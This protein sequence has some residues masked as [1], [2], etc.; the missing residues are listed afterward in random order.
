MCTAVSFCAA[1]R[2]F[3]RNLDLECF[4]DEAVTLLPRRAEVQ[5]LS[6]GRLARHAAVLGTA[7]VVQGRALY[8]D[9]MNEHGLAMAALHFPGCAHY[10]PATGSG[11][12]VASFELTE[13]LLCR[14]ASLSEARRA[15]QGLR[16]TDAAFSPDFPP[17]PL[18]WM[19]SDGHR[20]LVIEPTQQ[21]VQVHENP[22]GVLTNAPEFDWH[23]K[24]W[25]RFSLL[26]PE[27]RAF[28]LPGDHSSAA[29]FV[30]AHYVLQHSACAPEQE[31]SQLLGILGAVQV[32]RGSVRTPAGEAF[33]TRYTAAC[34]LQKLTYHV[35]TYDDLAVRSAVLADLDPDGDQVQVVLPL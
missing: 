19:L 32:P 23:L 31:L 2:W 5:F 22:V 6:A 26:T 10:A 1:G 16:I 9:A 4:A 27:S 21:G 33:F 14:C 35:R 20:S 11:R 18:H 15:L 12:E 29:R 25:Q 24:N 30:R 34:D 3:G 8:Y 7:R 17:T 28:G 13:Y